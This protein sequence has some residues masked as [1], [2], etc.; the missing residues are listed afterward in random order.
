MPLRGLGY[1]GLATP[2]PARWRAFAVDVIGLAPAASAGGG[3]PATLRLRMDE[4]CGRIAVHRAARGGLAYAGWEAADRD[5]L[6]AVAARLRAACVA[7]ETP[8]DDLRA[9]RG[10]TALVRFSDPWGHSHEV[11][12]GAA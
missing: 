2:D 9:E 8:S 6:E 4:R 7:V 5:G 12:T 11:F 1:L 10:V 3:D